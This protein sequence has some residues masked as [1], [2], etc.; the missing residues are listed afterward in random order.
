MGM[1]IRPGFSRDEGGGGCR[2]EFRVGS[3]D[4]VTALRRREFFAQG[5][6]KKRGAD[7]EGFGGLGYLLVRSAV[8]AR[9]VCIQ[10]TVDES[11]RTTLIESH[12]GSQAFI[13]P[14][15]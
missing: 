9:W 3:L 1:V 15:L 5:W 2:F 6:M 11:V 13:G 10:S 4:D 8:E 12:P 14:R 7:G